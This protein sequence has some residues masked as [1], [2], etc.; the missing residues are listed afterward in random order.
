MIAILNFVVL[1]ACGGSSGPDAEITLEGQR[2]TVAAE[3]WRS[4][5]SGAT[6]GEEPVCSSLIIGGIFTAK[7]GPFPPTVTVGRVQ[8][9]LGD[10]M[11]WQGAVEPSENYIGPDGIL[12]TTARDCF[13]PGLESRERVIVVYELTGTQGP[14]RVAAPEVAIQLAY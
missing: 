13:P 5:G 7:P 9:L 14:A 11:V 8:L 2:I 3:V 10:K 6:P 4:F 12:I 1:A